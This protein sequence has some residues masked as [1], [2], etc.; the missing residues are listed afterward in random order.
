MT[1]NDLN[2]E[3]DEEFKP[4]SEK[5]SRESREA[6]IHFFDAWAQKQMGA[7]RVVLRGGK[8][9]KKDGWRNVVEHSLITS[10]AAGALAELLD[11]PKEQHDAL[12]AGLAVHDWDKRIDKKK[13]EMTDER[14]QK[15]DAWVQKLPAG[16]TDA[17]QATKMTA[18]QIHDIA[19]QP[20]LSFAEIARYADT[21]CDE[22]SIISPKQRVDNARPRYKHLTEEYFQAEID[23]AG[24]TEKKIASYLASKG[25]EIIPEKIPELVRDMIEKKIRDA[26]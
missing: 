18:F 15:V 8:L 12:C 7:M 6:R 21:I 4:H 5:E 26:K 2:K 23:A 24:L 17:W 20:E 16:A 22:S 13:L 14:R 1:Q 3:G 25:M 10:L 19:K 9:T 11:L